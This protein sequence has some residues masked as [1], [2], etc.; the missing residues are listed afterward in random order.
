MDPLRLAIDRE[1]L[2]AEG[3]SV[4]TTISVVIPVT[5]R[6]DNIREIYREYRDALAVTGVPCDMIFVID[7]GFPYAYRELKA[8]KE[9]GEELTIVR[10]ARSFGEATA[11][12]SGFRQASGD[13]VMTLPAYRQVEAGELPK[14]VAQI[15]GRDMVIVRRWPRADSRLNRLQTHLFRALVRAMTGDITNDIGCSV[16]LMRREVLEE[17]VL[18]GDLHRFLPIMAQRQGFTV[19]EIDLPQSRGEKHVRAYPFG[20]YLRRMIDLLTVFFLIKFTKKPLRFFGLTGTALLAA[21]SAL[22][23]DLVFQRVVF[24]VGLSGRPL[25]LVGILLIVLGLQV[26]AIGLIGEIIIFTHARDLKEYHVQEIIN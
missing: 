1:R 17:I 21:G 11:L 2:P 20:I 7:G 25:L 14:L 12:M 19:V 9:E 6:H 23:I 5:E 8:L 16:R 24:D 15:E 22:T 18:Y 10:H 26:F 3:G 13:L 4:T